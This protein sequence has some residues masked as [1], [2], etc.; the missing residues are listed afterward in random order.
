[1]APHFGGV[2]VYASFFSSSSAFLAF[3]SFIPSTYP[4]GCTANVNNFVRLHGRYFRHFLPMTTVYPLRLLWDL[5]FSVSFLRCKLMRLQ[6]QSICT[7]A[8]S[9]RNRIN[10]RLTYT[11][12]P[13]WSMECAYIVHFLRSSFWWLLSLLSRLFFSSDCVANWQ[14]FDICIFTSLQNHAHIGDET[15]SRINHLWVG[16]YQWWLNWNL[17]HLPQNN[18]QTNSE[19]IIHEYSPHF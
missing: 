2:C 18:F 6:L 12:W 10:I 11:H 13:P 15:V 3:H 14:T 4:L 19:T 7:R 9:L 17:K 16:T 1:M 5:A 8:K